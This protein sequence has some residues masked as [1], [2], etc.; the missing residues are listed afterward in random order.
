[1]KKEA[2]SAASRPDIKGTVD[3][4]FNETFHSHGP[5]LPEPIFANFL[6][7]KDRLTERLVALLEK[8]G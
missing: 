7:A 1:M 4:W 5:A 8:E 6:A 3:A 2:P